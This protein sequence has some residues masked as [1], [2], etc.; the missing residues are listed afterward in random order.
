MWQRKKPQNYNYLAQCVCQQM[1]AIVGMGGEAT[2]CVPMSSS[3]SL[4]LNW[5]LVMSN[6]RFLKIVC[7]H[8]PINVPKKIEYFRF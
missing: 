2:T 4:C 3:I 5:H 1:E 8:F 6:Q 7:F